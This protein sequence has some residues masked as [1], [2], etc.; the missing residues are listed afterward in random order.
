MSELYGTRD[1]QSIEEAANSK[2]LMGMFIIDDIIRGNKKQINNFCESEEAKVLVGTSG[3]K[4]FSVY[5]GVGYEKQIANLK[6]GVDIVIGTPGRVIDLNEGGNLDLSNSHF[7]VIDEA[8]R[9]FDMGFYDD[10]R[11]ILKKLPEAETR[12]TMLFSATLNTYVKNL[13]WEYTRDPV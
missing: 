6:K 10:L 4:A 11:K 1:I 12:Q 9:M 3:L 5:G 2:E 13:A 7:C 8:D